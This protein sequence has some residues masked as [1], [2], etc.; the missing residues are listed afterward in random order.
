MDNLGR[1]DIKTYYEE[2]WENPRDPRDRVFRRLNRLIL[3]KLPPGEGKEALDVGAGRGTIV[4]FLRQKGYRAA[5]VE[6]NENFVR[7]LRQR[8]PDVEVI[9]GDFIGLAIGRTFDLVT[10]VEF[11]QNLNREDLQSFFRK[12]AALTDHLILT[13]SNKNSLHGFWAVFRGFIKPFVHVYTPK[14]VESLIRGAGFEIVSRRGI[15]LLTPITLFADFRW[16][17]IPVWL[18]TLINPWADRLFPR[19]CHLYYLEA[20]K[21]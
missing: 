11:I 3:K 15:G 12:V 8:F 5:A 2:W 7:E 6:F 20:R 21:R 10:A 19:R 16:K 14:E 13:V 9:E 17:L 18:T 1:G 4:D